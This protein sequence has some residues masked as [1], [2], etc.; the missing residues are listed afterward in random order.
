MLAPPASN[1]AIASWVC[2]Y[3]TAAIHDQDVVRTGRRRACHD[4]G[5]HRVR[6]GEVARPRMICCRS[7]NRR[8]ATAVY[9]GRPG[10]VA[11]D[12]LSPQRKWATMFLRQLSRRLDGGAADSHPEVR[13]GDALERAGSGRRPPT[14]YR[15]AGLRPGVLRPGGAAV[16]AGDRD[17]RPSHARGDGRGDLRPPSRPRRL[18][19]RL[20][21][22]PRESDRLRGAVRSIGRPRSSTCTTSSIEQ[23]SCTLRAM[24]E[25]PTVGPFAHRVRGRL[26]GDERAARIGPFAHRVVG[27]ERK[28]VR[29][30]A[31]WT[32]SSVPHS[33]R[34]EC[35]DSWGIADVDRRDAEPGRGDRADGRTA[36]HVVARHE[37]L[38]RH[39]GRVAG[40]LER[41]RRGGR[42]RVPLVGVDLDRRA[43]VDDRPVARLV[44]LGVVR[45]GPRG[46][47]RPRRRPTSTTP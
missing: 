36:R 16:A 12:W 47:C 14:R 28:W 31:R 40:P 2:T 18:V 22:P 45:D 1:P 24:S 27:Q 35:I 10:E 39:A 43:G 42:R 8:S 6:P 9:R 41:R 15:A 5:P 46:R 34:A 37:H 3:R 25:W 32:G 4:P 17:R 26:Q 23:R 44:A 38:P 33:S 7:S 21:R 11:V 19:D 13:F 29:A 20:A 30:A